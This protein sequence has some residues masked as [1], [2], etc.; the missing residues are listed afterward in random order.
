MTDDV[1]DRELGVAEY[2]YREAVRAITGQQ[3]V[4]AEIRSRAGLVAS[5]AAVATAFL[6]GLAKPRG[7]HALDGVL[8]IVLALGLFVGIGGLTLA[9]LW[10]RA[11]KFTVRAKTLLEEP[12][13]SDL[14]D[15]EIRKHLATYL[16][17]YYDTNQSTLDDMFWWLRGA[18]AMSGLQVLAWVYAMWR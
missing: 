11:F 5:T 14:S 8:A 4:L 9:I 1:A 16:D 7:D 13:W 15:G 18:I 6:A 12:G 2:A 17:D 3:A 10:P